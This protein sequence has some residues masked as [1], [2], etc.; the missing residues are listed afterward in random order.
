MFLFQFSNRVFALIDHLNEKG[1]AVTQQHLDSGLF[2]WHTLGSGRGKFCSPYFVFYLYLFSLSIYSRGVW[3]RRRLRICHGS[4]WIF[5]FGR[6]TRV[7]SINKFL[8]FSFGSVH[9]Q[10]LYKYCAWTNIIQILNW[11]LWRF[12]FMLLK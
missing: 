5:R 6:L 7:Y 3:R 4:N 8:W 10:A 12:H 9:K 1:V 11:T 2:P